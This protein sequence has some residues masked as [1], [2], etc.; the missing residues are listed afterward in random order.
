M[1]RT[2]QA[3][4]VAEYQLAQAAA[5]RERERADQ[6]ANL[7]DSVEEIQNNL[8]GDLLTEMWA[9]D[10]G[11]SLSRCKVLCELRSGPHLVRAVLTWLGLDDT[12]PML[13]CRQVHDD[14]AVFHGGYHVG[15]DQLRGGLARYQ[16]RGDDDVHF[17][18]LFGKQGHFRRASLHQRNNL[19]GV[20]PF[21]RTAL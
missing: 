17:P 13:L 6:I 8:A 2:Q 5:K 18:G 19:L 9:G 21:R 20:I 1:A 4:A 3:V 7:Q 14:A 15:R 10:A 12:R 16:G 11:V